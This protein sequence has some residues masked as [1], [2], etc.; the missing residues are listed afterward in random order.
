[1]SKKKEEIRIKKIYV[2]GIILVVLILIIVILFKFTRKGTDVS[3]FDT[4][5]PQEKSLVEGNDANLE[6]TVL[7]K[8][9]NK[10]NTSDKIK[11]EK[12]I[13]QNLKM[14]NVVLTCS[15]GKSTMQAVIKNESDFVVSSSMLKLEFYD[16]D[17]KLIFSD[18][19]KIPA[20]ASKSKYNFEY[21]VKK[22]ISNSYYVEIKKM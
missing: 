17:G 1:M 8:S 9:G 3:Y 13:D 21:I 18:T 14:E 11:E 16:N 7:D 20:I 4:L 2:T 10:I 12:I 6:N 15:K 22:D 5:T 19:T